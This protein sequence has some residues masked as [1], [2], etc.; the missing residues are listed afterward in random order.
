[1][2]RWATCGNASGPNPLLA[3][4]SHRDEDD[5]VTGRV[6]F[7]RFAQRVAAR[8]QHLGWRRPC[9]MAITDEGD[10][11]LRVID[12]AVVVNVLNAQP[13][14]ARLIE[15]VLNRRAGDALPRV[16]RNR[17]LTDLL[18]SHALDQRLPVDLVTMRELQCAAQ[19]R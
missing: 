9:V 11:E 4:V 13:R 17:A 10:P 2:R 12:V 1:M 19:R 18:L 3:S 15:I 6:G 14:F 7:Y 5:F 8:R 16:D